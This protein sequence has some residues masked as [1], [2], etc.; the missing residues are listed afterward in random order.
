VI[1]GGKTVS[2]WRVDGM[3]GRA[4]AVVQARAVESEFFASFNGGGPAYVGEDLTFTL[5]GL[6]GALV[7]FAIV[8]GT[9][10]KSIVH[11]GRDIT[12]SG[13]SLAGTESIDGVTIT[14]TTDTA[15]ID[16]TVATAD[17]Q[18]A[19]A[20]VVVF[21]EDASKWFPGSPF[22]HALHSREEAVPGPASGGA[23]APRATR[24][25]SQAGLQA[26]GFIAGYLL[27]G[28]YAVAVVADEGRPVWEAG[29]VP[30]VDRE[31]LERLRAGATVVGVG[32][33]ETATVHLRLKK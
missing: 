10:F 6:R 31:S 19:G 25:V 15:T 23:P 7:P 8:P 29:T 24:Q 1:E 28:R 3:T 27:P 33:G 5:T 4:P 11:G 13:L 14:V 16:G 21:P 12:S 30:P 18:P 9:A 20:W 2:G 26:G 22:V 17:G 32:A